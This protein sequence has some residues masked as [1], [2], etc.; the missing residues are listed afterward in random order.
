MN[1]GRLRVGIEMPKV[2]QA[3]VPVRMRVAVENGRR[4]LDAFGLGLE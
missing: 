3:G 2:V 1:L 4:M